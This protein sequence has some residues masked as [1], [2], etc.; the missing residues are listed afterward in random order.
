MSMTKTEREQLI[1]LARLRAKQAK[2]EAVQREKVLLSEVDDLMTV[3]FQAQDQLWAEAVAIHP[4]HPSRPE[5]EAGAAGHRGEPGRI[6]SEDRRNR[7]L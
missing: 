1:R 7:R 3:E 2:T 5:A 6:R 4:V